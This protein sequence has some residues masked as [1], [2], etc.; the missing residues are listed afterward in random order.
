MS[1]IEESA[2]R[3]EESMAP[4]FTCCDG[5]DACT[6]DRRNEIMGEFVEELTRQREELL[7]EYEDRDI[8]VTLET[9]QC[10]CVAQ[11]V[12]E[13]Y[14]DAMSPPVFAVYTFPH[15]LQRQ[16]KAIKGEA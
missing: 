2:K 16:I 1:Y 6:T 14:Q 11:M 4:H 9:E 8:V 3:F 10:L 7:K 5:E 13:K 15:W 12:Y